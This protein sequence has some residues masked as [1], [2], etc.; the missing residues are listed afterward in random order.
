MRIEKNELI[1]I[2]YAHINNSEFLNTNTA[3][4]IRV[5]ARELLGVLGFYF[6]VLQDEL[7]KL[8]TPVFWN[9]DGGAEYV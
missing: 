9:N 7:F 2:K 3:R 6:N 5:I 4:F 1:S 8:F